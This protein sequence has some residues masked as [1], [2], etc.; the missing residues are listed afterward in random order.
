MECVLPVFVTNAYARTY[1]YMQLLDKYRL[2]VHLVCKCIYSIYH[3]GLKYHPILTFMLD[4]D[5]FE[6]IQYDSD[7]FNAETANSA[8][9]NTTNLLPIPALR[10]QTMIYTLFC[11]EKQSEKKVIIAS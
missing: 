9:S 4:F 7:N 10:F 2:H 8:S 6:T 3:Q 5:I 11:R 1:H